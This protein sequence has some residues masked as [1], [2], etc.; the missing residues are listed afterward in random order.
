MGTSE[1]VYPGMDAGKAASLEA[2]VH[3]PNRFTSLDGD[4][5]KHTGGTEGREYH[6]HPLA[7]WQSQN[8][9]GGCENRLVC[10]DHRT[11]LIGSCSFTVHNI[12]STSSVIWV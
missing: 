6:S 7:T 4:A 12:T 5:T 9:S 8:G 2:R 3:T 11:L 1:V 10:H